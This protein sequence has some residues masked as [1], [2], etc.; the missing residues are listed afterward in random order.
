M[1]LGVPGRGMDVNVVMAGPGQSVM[2]HVLRL[3]LFNV[4][5]ICSNTCMYSLILEMCS[6]F[7]PTCPILYFNSTFIDIY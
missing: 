2:K 6:H 7:P 3:F 4:I 5:Y 1:G